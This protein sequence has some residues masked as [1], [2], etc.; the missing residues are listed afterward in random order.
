VMSGRTTLIIAHRPATIALA[1]RVV[2]LDSGRMVAEGTHD[3]LLESSERY[4][5][6]LAQA[7]AVEAAS[8]VERVP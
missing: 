7:A 6:V 2:L 8:T 3:E 1:D 5:E 4:R